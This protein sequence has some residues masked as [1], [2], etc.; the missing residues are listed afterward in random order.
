MPSPPPA[1]IDP[2]GKVDFP[3]LPTG[4][5]LGVGMGVPFEAA[6]PEPPEGGRLALYTD[7]LIESRDHDTD[8]GMKHLGAALAHP[9]RSLEDLCSSVIETLPTRSPRD[10]VTSLVVRTHPLSPSQTTCWELP[11]DPAVVRRARTLVTRRLNQWGLDRLEVSTQ[12]IISELVT[13][14]LR[15][16]A[17]P[18]RLRLI[19]HQV[20]TCKV[21]DTSNTLPRLRHACPND[22]GGRGLYIVAQ[23]CRRHAARCLARGGKT[24]WAELE[25]D[26]DAVGELPFDL[27][28]LGHKVVGAQPHR[29]HPLR[30][31]VA[32]DL[33][34]VERAQTPLPRHHAKMRD[35]GGRGFFGMP[36]SH[37]WTPR[38]NYSEGLTRRLC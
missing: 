11:S 36:G 32:A 19:R 24:V 31:H 16:A 20:L 30:R 7:R 23:H 27:A 38:T 17:V 10:A 4:R 6:E 37:R 13:N 18:I 21:S 15:H 35:Y 1:I 25:L 2:H 14:A 22:E 12:L 28:A 26:T 29:P 9:D 34:L 3:D 8:A 33:Q 5:P